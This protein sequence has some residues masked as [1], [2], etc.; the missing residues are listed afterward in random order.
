MQIFDQRNP[1][2][3]EAVFDRLLDTSRKHT[4]LRR[5][6]ERLEQLLASCASNDERLLICDILDRFTYVNGDYLADCL[7]KIGDRIVKIW[8]CTNDNTVIVAMDKSRYADSSSAIAW[9]I[10]PVLADLADWDTNTIYKNLTDAINAVEDGQKIVVVDEFVGSG[11]TLSGRLK[12]ISDELKK[13]GKSVEIYVAIVAAMEVCK[14]KDF[15]CAADFYATIWMKQAINDYCSGK[16]LDDAIDLMLGME[17]LLHPAYGN[18]QMKKYSLGYKKTQS[19]YYLENGN[20][21]NNNFPIFWWKRMK[22]GTRRRPLL[23][24]V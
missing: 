7:E 15:S 22:D 17:S 9:M 1:S 14:Q 6:H 16:C 12:W 24:R 23:P 2:L 18:L 21:P 13:R 20:P 4:W 3:P 8:G 5:R 11:K 10:K 19:A